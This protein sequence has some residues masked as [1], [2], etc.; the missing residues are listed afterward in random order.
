M[1][2]HG[3]TGT[4]LY[5][6]YS[7][8][9][10]R[11]RLSPAWVKKGIKVCDEWRNNSTAFFDWAMQSGYADNLTLDRIDPLGDYE[12]SNCRWIT[13][14]EQQYNKTINHRVTIH[15]KTQTIAEWS[16][17]SGIPYDTIFYRVKSGYAE[18][19]ILLP[20]GQMYKTDHKKR[21]HLKRPLTI[22]GETKSIKE[23]SEQSGI[24]ASTI[25]NRLYYGWSED[26]VLS[27]LY[28]KYHERKN[29][30]V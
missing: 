30:G 25:S 12:P 6:C 27:P 9:V 14:Q 8:M 28:S 24:S 18:N 10:Q 29:K 15:G 11:C 2:T 26:E 16:K 22:N 7:N 3:L 17:E 4:R 21:N 20:V 19:E 5:R 23:W 13:L 1:K